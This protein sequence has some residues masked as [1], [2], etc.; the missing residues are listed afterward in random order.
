MG[1]TVLRSMAAIALLALASVASAQQYPSRPV[2]LIVPFPPG[3]STDIVARII[4]QE[5]TAFWSN[6]VVVE[7]RAGA[8]GTIGADAVAK[9]APDGYTLLLA[10]LVTNA[11]APNIYA[12][13][14]YNPERD[15]TYVSPLTKTM[16]LLLV[17]PSIP[18]NSLQELIAYVRANKGKVAYSS[19]GVGLSGHLGMEIILQATG[20]EALNVPYKGSAPAAQGMMAGE[21]AMTLDL[22]PS[23]IGYLKSGKAKAIAVASDKRSPL[24]PDVPTFAEVGGPRVEIYTWNG[25]AAPASTPKEVVAKIHADVQTAMKKPEV[26]DRFL[27]MGADPLDLTAEEFPRFVQ[28]ES[29]KWGEVARRLG[30]RLD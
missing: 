18:A 25:I 15:F 19:P 16:N 20:M 12:K 8:G 22:V 2:K 23:S 6:P 17:H 30:I 24:L 7:N 14:P 29:K 21:T 3:G 13:L 9:A 10:T 11:T 1:L 26:R 5:L 28:S 27:K 4:A